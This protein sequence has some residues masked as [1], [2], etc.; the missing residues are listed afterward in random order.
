MSDRRFETIQWS[1]DEDAG[2]GSIVLNRPDSLN[3]LSTQLRTDF[4]A[5]LEAFSEVDENARTGGK[6]ATVRAIVVEGAGERAFCAGA[7]INEF[8]DV[9]PGVFDPGREFEVAEVFPAPVIAKIDGYCLGGGM[10]L[11]LSCDFRIASERSMLGQAEI[12][13]GI[14]PGGGGTQR[15]A[16]LVGP[17]RA[18]EL[19]MTGEHLTATEAETDGIINYVHPHEK[20][21][22]AVATFVERLTSKPPLAVRAVKDVINIYQETGLR[23]GRRYERRVIDTLRETKDHAEGRRAFTEERDPEWLG[24]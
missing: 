11:A 24:R 7:D 4:I 19:C 9:N 18:K 17:S 12:D 22:D 21:D 8:K 6:G 16:E 10:E 20:L 1:F 5:S 23:E 13:L 15:L 2:I 3:A 14:I